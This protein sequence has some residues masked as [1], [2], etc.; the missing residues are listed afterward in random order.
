MK[1]LHLQMI[2]IIKSYANI[3]ESKSKTDMQKLQNVNP[4]QSMKQYM[5]TIISKM[6]KMKLAILQRILNP[7]I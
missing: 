4:L 3:S 5:Q 6:K 2:P 7:N 1:T